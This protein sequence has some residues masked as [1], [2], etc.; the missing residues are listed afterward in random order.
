MMPC[1]DMLKPVTDLEFEG[2]L[3]SREFGVEV[4]MMIPASVEIAANLSLLLLH[5]Y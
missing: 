4:H 3:G 1:R 2:Y 5:T